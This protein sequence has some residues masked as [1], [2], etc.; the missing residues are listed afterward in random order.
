MKPMYQPV[1]D[2]NERRLHIALDGR[3]WLRHGRRRGVDLDGVHR[4]LIDATFRVAE[5]RGMSTVA[6]GIET[7]SLTTLICQLHCSRGQGFFV[8]PAADFRCAG[9]VAA[10]AHAARQRRPPTPPANAA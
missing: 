7:G 10:V 9:A 5:T 1:I 8:G 6:E 3:R 2:W 4:V